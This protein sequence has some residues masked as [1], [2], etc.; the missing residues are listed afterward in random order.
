MH[1]I[2]VES[3]QHADH[4]GPWH[5]EWQR[6][7]L[8]KHPRRHSMDPDAVVHLVG[9]RLARTAGRGDDEGLVAGAAEMLDHP[10]HRVVDAVDIREEGLS[11]DRNAHAK[12]V[13]SAAVVKVA[14]RHTTRKNLVP[15]IGGSADR[16]SRIVRTKKGG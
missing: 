1:D 5:P 14:T 6:C 16:D 9:R 10:K 8:G 12:R 3:T 4:P 13:P 11:D 15:M 2:R 7:D